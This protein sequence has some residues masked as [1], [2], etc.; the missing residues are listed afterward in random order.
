MVNFALIQMSRKHTE[1]LGTFVEIIFKNKWNLTIF[2]DLEQ[3]EY[4]FVK[5]YNQLFEKNID[6]QNTSLLET[7]VYSFDFFI[8]ASSTDDKRLPQCFTEY[9]INCKTIYVQHQAPHFKP[10]MLKNI[11]VSPVIQSLDLSR[12]YCEYILPIYKSYKKLHWKPLNK[13][14][15]FAVIGGIRAMTNGRLVD[16]NL[17]LVQEM[18][19][20]Y[21]NGDYEF[22]FF[23]RKW[24]WIWISKKY[25]FLKEN[26]KIFGFAGLE[27][28]LLVKS[29][30]RVKFILPLAKKEGWFYWQRLTGSIPLAINFNIPMIIDRELANI[31]NLENVSLIYENSM[32]E[33]YNEIINITDEEY[34]K[35]VEKNVKYKIKKCK[36]NERN[37]I[38]LCL[39]QI[40]TEIKEDFIMQLL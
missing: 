13:T 20:K 17:E 10:F 21:P 2:Y 18:L 39:T 7:S 22:W 5:F 23:M 9:E 24:D 12:K 1:I 6:V 19:K 15:V 28:D 38:S 11:T 32:T 30:H 14:T 37:F 36:D 33:I 31:Y 25:K 34:F 35:L 26:P 29:L 4:T 8:V 3:D 27:T 40:S 16:K